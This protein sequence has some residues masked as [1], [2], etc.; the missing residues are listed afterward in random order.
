MIAQAKKY[1][2][3]KTPAQRRFLLGVVMVLCGV[4]LV[5]SAM[6]NTFANGQTLGGLVIGFT[7][8]WLV[9]EKTLGGK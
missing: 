2:D 7:G 8:L 3:S 4:V 5:V 9:S 1:M 6:G